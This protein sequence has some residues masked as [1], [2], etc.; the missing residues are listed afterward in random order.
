[1]NTHD[2]LLAEFPP[3]TPG[4]AV[5]DFPFVQRVGL[6]LL[7]STRGRAVLRLPIEPNVNHVGTVYAGALFTLAEAP[8]GVLFIKAFDLTRFYPIVGAL[9]IRFRKPATTSVLVDGRMTDEEID[10][11]TTELETIGKSKWVLETELVDESGVVVATTTATY[12]GL[13]F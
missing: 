8:G 3:S 10:R 5:T 1:V 11:V 7:H 2:T 12:F 9:D 13:A 4:R 6:E